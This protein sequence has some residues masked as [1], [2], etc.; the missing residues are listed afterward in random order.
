LLANNYPYFTKDEL[1]FIEKKHGHIAKNRILDYET[2]LKSLM[3]QSKSKQLMKI[4]FYLNQLPTKI[5]IIDNKRADYWE[6]P[7]EF[8]TYGSGD[9]EDYAIIK[10]FTLLKLGFSKDKLFMTTAYEKYSG[11]YHM[12]LSYFET[13]N[14]PPLVLDNLSFEILD[15]RK[16]VDL[17]PVKFINPTGTY[18]LDEDN[19]LVKI[20]EEHP[21]FNELLQRVEREG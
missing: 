18:K 11:Q 15:L 8:L 3:P 5:D 12:I 16:R 17:K 13:L 14:K 19:H 6:T 2:M 9:C 21:K 7:K 1:L 10:Y 20:A 4:N